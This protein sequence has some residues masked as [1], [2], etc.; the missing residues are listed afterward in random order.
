MAKFTMEN[1]EMIRKRDMEFSNGLTAGVIEG[2]GRMGSNTEKE[3]M[4]LL[5]TKKKKG[6]GK[7]ERG[8]SGFK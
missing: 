5:T 1:T 7:K 8:L 6:S 3:F 2:S 4:L